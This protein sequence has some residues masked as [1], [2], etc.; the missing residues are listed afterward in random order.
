MVGLTACSQGSAWC[1]HM[2]YFITTESPTSAR[3]ELIGGRN[4]G[5]RGPM[6]LLNLRPLHRNVIFAIEN[7]FS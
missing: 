2:Q 7:H 3:G 5:A 1:Y 6:P 4:R